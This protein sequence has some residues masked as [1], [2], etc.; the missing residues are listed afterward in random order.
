MHKKIELKYF[1]I[2]FVSHRSEQMMPFQK[3]FFSRI[4]FSLKIIFMSI[5]REYQTYITLSQTFLV[6]K[7][8]QREMRKKYHLVAISKAF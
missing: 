6:N 8:M 2:A 7:M 3:D 1:K 4:K 5:H